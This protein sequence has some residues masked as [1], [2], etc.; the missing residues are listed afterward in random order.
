MGN[1]NNLYFTF[2]GSQ[3]IASVS[4]YEMSCIGDKIDFIFTPTRIHFFDKN[5]E[6]CY[7]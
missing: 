6:V 7:V 2:G 3:S 1:E 4:K 5:T